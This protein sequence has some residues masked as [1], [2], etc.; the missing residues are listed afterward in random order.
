MQYSDKI[1]QTVEQTIRAFDMVQHGDSVLVGLSGGPD[2]V[3]LVHVL[4]TLAPRY[5]LRLGTAHLNHC[6]RGKASDNDAKFTE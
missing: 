6:L 1:F 5:G 4:L 2:S 3:A